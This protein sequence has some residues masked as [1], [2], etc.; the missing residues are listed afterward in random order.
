MVDDDCDERDDKIR[1]NI[2]YNLYDS[3]YVQ[4][5]RWQRRRQLRKGVDYLMQK[6]GDERVDLYKHD[7]T[8]ASW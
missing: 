6:S 1:Y 8:P 4:F 3:V 2:L 5:A 7:I